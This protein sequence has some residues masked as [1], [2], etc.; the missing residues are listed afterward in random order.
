MVRTF[1]DLREIFRGRVADIGAGKSPYYDLIAPNTS[2]YIAI[3]Y[4]SSLP[5]QETR[6]IKRVAGV[7][8]AIPLATQSIDAVFCSQVLSQV[9]YPIDA[10]HE[11]V[12]I[13]RPG[14][15][16]IISVP[17]VSPIH[18]EPYDLYRFTPDGLSK[19]AEATGLR[20]CS[21]YIQGQLFAS[22]AL[23]FAMNLVLKPIVHEHPM[24]LLPQRQLLFAPLIAI[25]NGMAYLL[26]KILPFN[27]TPVNF[28]LV[29][30]KEQV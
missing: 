27:R 21:V 9:Q 25:V 11:I 12:R 2:L 20:T 17:H 29:S 19:L 26:D 4:P 8:E 16:A 7:I 22:F 28:I 13:L 10:L 14:G 24:R 5:Q 6:N 1:W 15:Y 18:S 30:V 23:C 3:D